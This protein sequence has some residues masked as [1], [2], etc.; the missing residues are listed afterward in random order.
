MPV[1]S[2]LSNIWIGYAGGT[3]AWSAD[4]TVAGN[5]MIDFIEESITSTNAFVDANGTRGR[6]DPHD[7]RVFQGLVT[8]GGR[9]SWYPTAL[10]WRFIV[11]LIMG[12]AFSS[13]NSDLSNTS[14]GT[15]TLWKKVNTEVWIY[16]VA[17][18]RAVISGRPGGLA[19]LDLDLI[20]TT[21]SQATY[22]SGTH[23]GASLDTTTT[24]FVYHDLSTHTVNAVSLTPAEV[25]FTVDNMM[26]PRWV[27]S[28]TATALYSAGK[29][30]DV[31]LTFPYDLL[32]WS[33]YVDN[34]AHAVVM[35]FSKSNQSMTLTAPKVRW[36]MPSPV[37]GPDG[38][39]M[40]QLAGTAFYDSGASPAATL[41]INVDSIP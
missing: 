27:N 3:T 2:K 13:H 8:V 17:V 24:A 40:Q 22:A 29:R 10:E 28:R 14:P 15:F 16:T 19:R 4:S 32:T 37:I 36:T 18:S 26:T 31:G 7:A 38:E 41:R 12:S 23:G 5:L 39:V 11:P 1:A 20:G 6:L 9:L 21:Y 33:S 30:V 25:A 35:A 34:A